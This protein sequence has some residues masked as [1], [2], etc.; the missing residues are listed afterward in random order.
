[1]QTVSLHIGIIN[2]TGAV[3]WG[4]YVELSVWTELFFA[5][6][7]KLRRCMIKRL[8]VAVF[9]DMWYYKSKL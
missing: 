2:G 9:F 3:A 5:E 6:A 1:M 4:M 7:E 8:Y